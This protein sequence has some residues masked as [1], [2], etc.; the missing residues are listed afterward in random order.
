MFINIDI[1][2]VNNIQITAKDAGTDLSRLR[3]ELDTI[4]PRTGELGHTTLNIYLTPEVTLGA[5]WPETL[6]ALNSPLWPTI[7]DA[8]QATAPNDEKNHEA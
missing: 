4:N 3:V 5:N 2:T 7:L 1:L 6:Q 8:L